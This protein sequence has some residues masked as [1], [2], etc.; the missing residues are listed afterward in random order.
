M[1]IVP[2]HVNPR[3]APPDPQSTSFSFCIFPA[4]SDWAVT[5]QRQQQ[6]VP[7]PPPLH[8][9]SRLSSSCFLLH[10]PVLF[11]HPLSLTAGRGRAPC[12]V[13]QCAPAP[14][15]S[16]HLSNHDGWQGACTAQEE[17][18]QQG[19]G[20]PA[21]PSM[22]KYVH[23]CNALCLHTC[24]ALCSALTCVWVHVH[25]SLVECWLFDMSTSPTSVYKQSSTLWPNTHHA[26]CAVC[27]WAGGG[28]RQRGSHAAT[29]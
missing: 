6:H 20:G 19:M 15:S 12:R 24:N 22:G 14:T 27:C 9:W 1:P 4:R 5:Q 26:V 7:V 29:V 11:P 25:G 17:Q 8:R 10:I 3:R 2:P 23:L 18:R 13:G 16:G 21:C 28:C